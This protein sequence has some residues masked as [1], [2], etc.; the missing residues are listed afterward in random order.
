MSRPARPNHGSVALIRQIDEFLERVRDAILIQRKFDFIPR[1]ENLDG[2]SELGIT[3]S[4]AKQEILALTYQD[5]YRG[6]S[7]DQ[8]R[9]HV[10]GGAIW[11]FIRDMDGRPVYIKLK[12]DNCRGCV[13]MSFHEADRAPR[14]PYR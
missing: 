3:I 1:R 7:P 4:A 11:E 12:L 8:S 9:E 6:P 14:L 10:R 13:C 2:L 5:Y